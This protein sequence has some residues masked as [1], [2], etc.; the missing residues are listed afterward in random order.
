M[1]ISDKMKEVPKRASV[2]SRYQGGHSIFF[3]KFKNNSRTFP[4]H[5][6]T[7]QEHNQET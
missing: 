4:K 5:F 6:V 7:F 2:K 1:Q 3:K